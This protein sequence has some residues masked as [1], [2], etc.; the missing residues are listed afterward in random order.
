M[1]GSIKQSIQ[2]GVN[3]HCEYWL[4]KWE[5]KRWNSMTHATDEKEHV[6]LRSRKSENVGYIFTSGTLFYLKRE[7]ICKEPGYKT[8]CQTPCS[9][10]WELISCLLRGAAHPVSD[11]KQCGWSHT[12]WSGRGKKGNPKQNCSESRMELNIY[13]FVLFT[14]TEDAKDRLHQPKVCLYLR[15]FLNKSKHWEKM[16]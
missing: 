16:L 3:T 13:Y 14:S 11:I 15:S 7:P 10:D 1:K 6:S 5:D 12:L 2:K 8:S 4:M 9:L